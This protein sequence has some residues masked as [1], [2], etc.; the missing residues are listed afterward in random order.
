MSCQLYIAYVRRWKWQI[1]LWGRCKYYWTISK[2][3]NH[4]LGLETDFLSH[5]TLCNKSIIWSV[6]HIITSFTFIILKCVYVSHVFFNWFKLTRPW[7]KLVKQKSN[8]K[9]HWCMNNFRIS[10]SPRRWFCFARSTSVIITAT[11]IF[12]PSALVVQ[13]VKHRES[14]NWT[15]KLN[16]KSEKNEN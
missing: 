13:N 5:G 10:Q 16:L 1:E 7:I 11:F 15:K 14:R 12:F 6:S 8:S 9:N 3:G 4:G 2:S